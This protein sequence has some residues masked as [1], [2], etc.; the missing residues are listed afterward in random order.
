MITYIFVKFVKLFCLEI[1]CFLFF[2]NVLYYKITQIKILWNYNRLTIANQ[3][4][5]FV[6]NELPNHQWKMYSKI[7]VIDIHKT[8]CVT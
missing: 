2:R 7:Y 4:F 3:L 5:K 1:W 6:I 8:N